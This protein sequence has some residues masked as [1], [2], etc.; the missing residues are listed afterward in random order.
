MENSI[1][2]REQR[3]KLARR[4][5]SSEARNEPAS[6]L[7]SDLLMILL[8]VPPGEKFNPFT[9]RTDI[10]KDF[11]LAGWEKNLELLQIL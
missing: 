1:Y 3:A 11:C 2:E 4:L 9:L 7:V 10:R 8:L 5:V 6:G